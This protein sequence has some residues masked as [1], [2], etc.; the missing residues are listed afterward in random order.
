VILDSIIDDLDD[1]DALKERLMNVRNLLKKL[2]EVQWISHADIVTNLAIK[3][4][5]TGK[6]ISAIEKEVEKE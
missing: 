5:K 1:G 4:G 3:V 6:E 2:G